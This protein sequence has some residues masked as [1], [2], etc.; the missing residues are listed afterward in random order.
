[1]V[2]PPASAGKRLDVFLAS[3]IAQ[4]SRSQLGRHIGQGA[5]T[6]NGAASAPSRKLRVGDVVVWTPP[7]V[8][9]TEVVAEDI[10][11][12]IVHE[13]RWLV[14]V[15]KPAGLVVHPAAGHEAGTLVNALLGHCR[16]LR[17]IGGELRPGIVHRIDKDTSGLLVV[18]KDDATMN[19]LGAAFK[20]HTIERVY[21]A[22]VV[23]KPPGSGGRIDT[24]Y[25]RDPK[26]RK[27]FSSRVRAGK[28]A[29][30]N[31]KVV[32]RWGG[33]ARVEAR[34]ETGRTHQVRVHLAALGCPLLGD[35][36][37]G[38]TPRD[39]ALRPIAETLGRQALHARMLGF[40]HPATG[41]AMSFSS[42]LPADLRAVLAA[43]RALGGA[44]A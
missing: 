24:L 38:R 16:D 7:P 2:V 11:L 41:K 40:V 17:G 1:L 31:W 42:E 14:V 6:V 39:P 5:V 18:A 29:V 8:V 27:K 4:V 32:E 35:R 33:A 34:L 3:A 30:T 12:T 43:L 15:D 13:D 9:P 23:G 10:P 26:D 22:F 19:A 25:G 44:P 20:A 28:R 37:Y 36:T 21:E